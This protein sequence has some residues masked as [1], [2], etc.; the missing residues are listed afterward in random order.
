MLWQFENCSDRGAGTGA[1]LINTRPIFRRHLQRRLT[2][3]NV[4]IK[5]A[6]RVDVV[7]RNLVIIGVQIV[8]VGILN[9]LTSLGVLGRL[10]QTAFEDAVTFKMTT[11]G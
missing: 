11:I 1:E 9:L 2:H 4:R 6:L 10:Y 8:Q 7:R 5:R 3:G